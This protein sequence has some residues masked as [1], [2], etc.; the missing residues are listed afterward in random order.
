MLFKGPVVV[1]G[2]FVMFIRSG[3]FREAP[4][5]QPGLNVYPQTALDAFDKFTDFIFSFFSQCERFS[6]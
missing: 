5:R 2:R 1:K 6:L 4:D 3:F